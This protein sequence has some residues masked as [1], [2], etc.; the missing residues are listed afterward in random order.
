[1]E[2]WT[3]AYKLSDLQ[4]WASAWRDRAI[5]IS[6]AGQGEAGASPEAR[7]AQA[8]ARMAALT[9]MLQ[10]EPLDEA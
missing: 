2:F 5:N 1:M 9:G 6:A 3:A 7:R 8:R 4:A 10:A